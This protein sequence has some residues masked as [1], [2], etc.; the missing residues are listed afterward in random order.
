MRF[1]RTAIMA[2]IASTAL[3]GAAFAAG[4]EARMMLVAYPDGTV[5]HVPVEQVRMVAIPAA[6]A[7]L[8]EAA[9]GP[10]SAFAEMDRIA[11]AMEARTTAMMRQAAAIQASGGNEGGNGIVMTNAQ[12][13]PVGVMHYSFVSTSTD[14]GGCTRTISYSSDGARAADQPRVIRTSAGNC[15]AQPAPA[16]APAA[17]APAKVT[18][19]STRPAAKPAPKILPVS[20]PKPEEIFTPSRT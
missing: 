2:G 3:A 9:F 18:P 7:H 11:A 14:A 20:A 1:V 4:R 16:I 10:D 13:Q 12:G 15:D 19:T 17:R 6:P 5:E 8:F